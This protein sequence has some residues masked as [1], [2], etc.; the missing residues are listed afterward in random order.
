MR[1][2]LKWDV[3]VSIDLK[4]IRTFAELKVLLFQ[5]SGK[6]GEALLF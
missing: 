6:A 4:K 5:N 2:Y 3:R 1:N